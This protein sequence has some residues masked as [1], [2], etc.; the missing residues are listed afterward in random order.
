MASSKFKFVR[1]VCRTIDLINYWTGTLCSYVIFLMVLM[2]TYEVICRYLFNAPTVWSGE[3]SQYALCVISMLGGG[4]AILL[5]EHVRVDILY[6]RFSTKRQAAIDLCTWW[7]VLVFC[8][9]LVWKGGEMAVESYLKG[10]KSMGFINFPMYPSLAMI[11]IGACLMLLQAVARITR[12][13]LTL[14]TEENENKLALSRLH[15]AEK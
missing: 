2:M 8:F 9:V 15:K 10:E 6:Q 14:V 1:N 7:L 11:P 12:N 13:V 5:D 3:L 4:Y